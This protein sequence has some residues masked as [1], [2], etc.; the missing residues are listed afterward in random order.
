M[1]LHPIAEFL[2]CCRVARENHPGDSMSYVED[3]ARDLAE[4]VDVRC[5]PIVE[6]VRRKFFDGER[7]IFADGFPGVEKV[8]ESN[9]VRIVTRP[10]GSHS[11]KRPWRVALH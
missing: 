4:A 2:A 9:H 10:S 8:F 1:C 7:R 11:T 5:G 3:M 6:I